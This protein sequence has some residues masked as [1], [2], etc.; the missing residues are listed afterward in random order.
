MAGRKRPI[1]NIIEFPKESRAAPVRRLIPHRLRDARKAKRMTQGGLGEIVGVTRQAI[2]AY[3][4]S[5][6]SPDSET[7]AR[8]IDALEQPTAFFTR[9]DLSL[10]GEEKPR[11]FR[12]CGPE[13]L[14]KNEACEILGR[15]FV[16]TVKYYDDYVNFPKVNVPD[17]PPTTETESYSLEEI[18]GTAE[19]CRHAWGLGVGPISNVLALLES[20]GI[21]VCRYEMEN[22]KIDAF[23]FWNGG[24]P[25]IFMASDK[26]S[27]A[28]HRYDLA[29][30]LGHLILHKWVEAEELKIPKTLKRLEAEADTFAGAFLLPRRSFPNEVYTSR[31][32]AF[33]ELKKRWRVSIQSMIYRCRDLEIIDADQF[34][35]LYKQ[36]SFRKWRTKEPLDDPNVMPLEQPKLLRRAVELILEGKR[37][38]PDEV[39]SDL[40]FSAGLIE[41]FCNLPRG[42]F[43]RESY[44]IFDP[45]LK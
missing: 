29:H 25:F 13:T 19:V 31:L 40:N 32:D 14:R 38:H 30:E 6:K 4:S 41:D 10:F 34:T 15:W 24:R 8:I 44:D 42:T 16:Q 26:E 7:F 3:E 37:K 17:P 11:F 28:R 36:I 43:D 45:S 5:E 35:N 39:L 9:D 27:V 23:S 21:V 33:V 12:K 2:S 20:K 22:E 18:E 1:K